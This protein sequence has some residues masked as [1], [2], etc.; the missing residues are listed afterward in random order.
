[1]YEFYPSSNLTYLKE[2]KDINIGNQNDITIHTV[3][4]NETSYDYT[5]TYND[6][7][8][9]FILLSFC[10]IGMA[11]CYLC[12]KTHDYITERYYTDQIMAM[13]EHEVNRQ[14]NEILDENIEN[15]QNN[16]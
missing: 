11:I 2:G 13:Y 10:V 9:G 3:Y 12:G 4:V 14:I 16:V 8:Q 7:L 1:M 5:S 15:G 6:Y